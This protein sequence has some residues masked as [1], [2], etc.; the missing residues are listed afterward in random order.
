M[1]L[2]EEE[3]VGLIA[4]RLEQQEQLVQLQQYAAFAMSQLDPNFLMMVVHPWLMSEITGDNL[5]IF[6]ISSAITDDKIR[7]THR[8][9]LRAESATQRVNED[10]DEIMLAEW[11][12]LRCA[13]VEYKAVWPT[14]LLVLL[15]FLSHRQHRLMMESLN[16]QSIQS[17]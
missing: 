6:P 9:L 11:S 2:T 3:Q 7:N 15:K 1:E 4:Q 13:I 5:Q 12:K 14:W 10:L 16:V 17:S 8:R